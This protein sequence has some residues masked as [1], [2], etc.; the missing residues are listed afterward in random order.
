MQLPVASTSPTRHIAILDCERNVPAVEEA[1]GPYFS[2]IFISVLQG[3]AERLHLSS[4]VRVSGYDVIAGQY[5]DPS[6][7]DAFI[8]TGSMAGAYDT[9]PWIQPLA[10]FIKLVYKEY[11]HVRISGVCFGHQIICQA[12]CGEHG[13]I[14][15]KHPGGFEFGLQTVNMDPNLTA[16]FPG[17]ERYIPSATE[18]NG[19]SE[20]PQLRLQ[21][22]HGDHVVLPKPPQNLPGGWMALGYTKHCHVQGLFE[23]GRVLT[24]QPHW[25]FDSFIM[26]ESISYLFTP[27]RGFPQEEVDSWIE[28]TKGKHDSLMM[29]EWILQFLLG[30]LPDSGEGRPIK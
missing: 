3:A 29:Q 12:L 9:Y 27:E 25:E 18:P 4:T 2:G 21:L 11:P 6:I 14:V 5:P 7:I 30:L 28:G 8:V 23:P 22:G 20:A 10:D 17:L 16:Y 24:S 26:S 13:V 1:Y 15:E 19:T